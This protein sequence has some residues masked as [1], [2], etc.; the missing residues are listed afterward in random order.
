MNS[1][2]KNEFDTVIGNEWII[3]QIPI[4]E[5][6]CFL[7][8]CK[9]DRRK[10]YNFILDNYS[11]ELSFKIIKLIEYKK[12]YEIDEFI[13]EMISH[14]FYSLARDFWSFFTPSL[15]GNFHTEE[16]YKDLCQKTLK[17]M[18]KFDQCTVMDFQECDWRLGK[19]WDL[20]CASIDR[21]ID[22]IA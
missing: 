19:K 15:S 1:G 8:K 7:A 11:S 12:G 17:T 22:S 6:S 2:N 21:V 9:L 10:F 20:D 5:M 4:N 18:M 3:N 13:N 14:A 16:N